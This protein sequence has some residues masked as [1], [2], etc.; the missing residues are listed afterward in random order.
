MLGTYIIGSFYCSQLR[1]LVLYITKPMEANVST[2][3]LT[4]LGIFP[5]L[6]QNQFWLKFTVAKCG[7]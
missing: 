2:A 3:T 1:L 7:K 5:K 6:K 4:A